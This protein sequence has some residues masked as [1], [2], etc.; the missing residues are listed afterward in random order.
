[1]VIWLLACTLVRHC[2]IAYR[3]HD[4]DRYH[5]ERSHQLAQSDVT[6]TCSEL[7]AEL[8][9]RNKAFQAGPDIA[10]APGPLKLVATTRISRRYS[11]HRCVVYR[12]ALSTSV[13]D[14][15]K[16]FSGRLLLEGFGCRSGCGR[17]RS[18]LRTHQQ[19]ETRWNATVRKT[20][21]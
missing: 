21:R 3:C 13:F 12:Y 10:K 7:L 2:S 19:D 5:L 18:F 14:V 8:K 1:M 17:R 9:R 4:V 15:A 16:W 20:M 6:S 11:M